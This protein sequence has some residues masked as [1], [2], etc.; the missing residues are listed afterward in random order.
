[1]KKIT[2]F[3]LIFTFLIIILALCFFINLA[4]ESEK[5]VNDLTDYYSNQNCFP[6]SI[7]KLIS[8][9]DSNIINLS[10]Y[11]IFASAENFKREMPSDLP[12][13][14][15]FYPDID[16]NQVFSFPHPSSQLIGL[17]KGFLFPFNDDPSKIIDFYLK[18][19]KDNNWEI[20]RDEE[21]PNS[22]TI[23]FDTTDDKKK[24]IS[25]KI[26]NSLDKSVLLPEDL[27]LKGGGLIIFKYK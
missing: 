10:N 23:I 20:N 2:I 7:E 6:R 11:I 13:S 25:F 16:L 1:M 15:L 12:E 24:I 14:F 27:N 19:A 21:N 4:F 5:R 3:S 22:R 26:I 17:L 18:I 9:D 8:K